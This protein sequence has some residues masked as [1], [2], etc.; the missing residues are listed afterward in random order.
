MHLNE[1][2]E[3]LGSD[4]F[5]GSAIENIKVPS[6]LKRIEVGTFSWCCCLKSVE[7]LN[8]VKYIENECFEG[9]GIE[10]ITL[11]STLSEIGKNAFKDLEHLVVV[12]VEKGCPIEIRKYVGNSVKVKHCFCSVLRSPFAGLAAVDDSSGRYSSHQRLISQL[13]LLIDTKSH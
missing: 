1:G 7:I 13:L 4:T 11:P 9:S 8:G 3:K 2:L 10:E 6:T 5:S 12:W